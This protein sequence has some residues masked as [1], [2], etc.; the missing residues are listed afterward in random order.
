MNRP[1]EIILGLASNYPTVCKDMSEDYQERRVIC[2]KPLQRLALCVIQDISIACY[3]TSM[4]RQA[5][6][7]DDRKAHSI[8]VQDDT[9]HLS[10][11]KN[12]PPAC[13]LSLLPNRHHFLENT[14]R[15]IY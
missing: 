2:I 1:L 9:R 8:I 4:C 6:E 15:S 3:L 11:D 14:D 12:P 10:A 7:L 5:Q 13:S